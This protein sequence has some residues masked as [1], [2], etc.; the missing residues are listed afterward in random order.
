MNYISFVYLI[1]FIPLV[2]L[3]YKIMPKRYRGLVLLLASYVFF[4]MVSKKLV[5]YLMLSTVSIYFIG[6]C[7]SSCKKNYLEK[8]K[9]ADDIKK[10]KIAFTKRKRRILLIGI[11]FNIGILVVLKYFNFI[12]SN[13]NPILNLL[14]SPSLLPELKFALP[15]GIS[16]YTLQAVSYIVDVYQEKIEADKKLP[17]LALFMSF[18]PI[19]MEGPI[20]RYSD[21]AEDLYR[22]EPLKYENVTFGSQRVLW[23]LF[24]NIVIADRL[25]LIVKT[26]FDN[27]EK[28]GGIVVILGAVCY[29]FQLYMNFSGTI[30]ITIGISEIFG[31]K[32]PENFRQP[33]FSKTAAEFWQR[34]HITL[35]T[36]FKDYIFYPISLTKF[37]KKLGKKTRKKFGKHIG[38]V[39]PS[40][41]A[42]FAVWLSNGLW[43]GDRWSYIFFGMYY[44]VLILL[45]KIVEP[46]NHKVLAYLK[47]DKHNIFY[48]CIQTIKMLIIV[49]TGELFFRANGLK[50]GLSMFKS[51]FTKFSWSDVTDGTILNLG[52]SYKDFGVLLAALIVVFIVGIYNERGVSIRKK[53]SNWNIFF[54]WSFYYAAL[55]IVIIFGAYGEGYIPAELIYAGF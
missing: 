28:Y 22:G 55:L 20:C 21:I 25:N 37:V 10:L 24:K 7:L 18:F 45:G 38:Q 13:I 9:N 53:I 50:A 51:I 39:I 4:F 14:S 54:R 48:R 43:H 6:I 35:G 17:R 42:L 32:I 49:F 47:I 16:F 11:V 30:D 1:V 26:I 31:I 12:A 23:G 34:W 52:I 3:A 8:E 36:W 46:L 29:T 41:I 40:M 15:I 27:Y 2:L 19:I 33:F 5:V 44:F